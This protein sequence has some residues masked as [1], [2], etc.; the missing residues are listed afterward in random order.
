MLVG[1]VSRFIFAPDV[2]FGE[3]GIPGVLPGTFLLWVGG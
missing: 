3:P 1:E 2:A